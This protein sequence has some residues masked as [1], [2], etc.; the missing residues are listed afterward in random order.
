MSGR[1][2][3]IS[4]QPFARREYDSFGPGTAEQAYE[5]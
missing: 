1:R 3:L 5:E 2:P 4:P